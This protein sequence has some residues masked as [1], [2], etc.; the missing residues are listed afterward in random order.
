MN[1]D[2]SEDSLRPQ[3]RAP[4][5]MEGPTGSV[6]AERNDANAANERAVAPDYFAT[7]VLE[8]NGHANY[9]STDIVYP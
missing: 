7:G 2:V 5:E 9:R 4:N 1:H 3:G 6:V 8:A